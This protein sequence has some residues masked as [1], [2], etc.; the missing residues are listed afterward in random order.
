MIPDA[1][2]N[3][4]RLLLA[5]CCCVIA[6]SFLFSST[7]NTASIVQKRT[8]Q[9]CMADST[10]NVAYFSDIYNTGREFYKQAVATCSKQ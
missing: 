8:L 2:F 7:G 6:S 1:V 9:Y 4:R 5:V 3:S 10:V